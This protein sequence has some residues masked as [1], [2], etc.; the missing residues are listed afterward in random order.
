MLSTTLTFGFRRFR[1]VPNDPLSEFARLPRS[2][3]HFHLCTLCWQ[4]RADPCPQPI[5]LNPM[6]TDQQRAAFR[7][8]ALLESDLV[9]QADCAT[10]GDW[11]AHLVD[12][13]A[14]LAIERISGEQA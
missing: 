7:L 13:L 3:A 1:H 2:L 9:A 12:H 4:V 14:D 5:T 8:V 6:N 11:F 10:Y